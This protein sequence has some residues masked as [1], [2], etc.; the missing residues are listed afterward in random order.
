MVKLPRI[1]HLKVVKANGREYA[2]FDTGA[3]VNGKTVRVRCKHPAQPGFWDQYAA[4]MAGRTKRGQATYTVAEL[5]RDYMRSQEFSKKAENTQRSYVYHLSIVERLWPDAPAGDLEPSDVS[6]AIEAERWGVGT[7]NMVLA[8]LGIIYKWGRKNKSKQVRN[9]PTKDLKAA[10]TGKHDA[11]P[12]DVLEEALEDPAL[13]LPVHL[14][15]FTGLRIGDA[16]ALRWGQIRGGVITITPQKTRRF[17]KTLH[18]PLAAALAEEL[19]RTPRKSLYV[20]DGFEERVL[21]RM[22]SA[23]GKA[24]GVH[25]VPHG[26]RTNAVEALLLAECSVAEVAAI[27]GH[28]MQMVEHYAAKINTRRLGKT[29]ILKLDAKRKIIP[30]TA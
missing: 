17:N 19:E 27:T 14:M 18:I 24:R 16:M 28:T 21:R 15:A 4:L 13:R 26:L 22:V 10:K 7:H 9:E 6:E 1:E 3:K 12:E 11:W 5:A 23:F 8:V 25:I 2:Y 20:L 30:K 29:A